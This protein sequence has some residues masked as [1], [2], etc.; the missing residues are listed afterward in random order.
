MKNMFS[1]NFYCCFFFSIVFFSTAFLLHPKKLKKKNEKNNQSKLFLSWNNNCNN[2]NNSTT[3]NSTIPLKY[4][5]TE[6][7]TETEPEPASE[8]IELNPNCRRLADHVR[9]RAQLSAGGERCGGQCDEQLTDAVGRGVLPV[10]SDT[11]QHQ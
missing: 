8:W 10:Q 3:N 6:T 9:W 7:E 2:N 1:Y 4:T 5:K 11:L